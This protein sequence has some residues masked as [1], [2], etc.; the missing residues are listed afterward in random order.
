[1]HTSESGDPA[2]HV[3][4]HDREHAARDLARDLARAVD[5]GDTRLAW[6]VEGSWTT[7]ADEAKLDVTGPAGLMARVTVVVTRS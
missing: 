7:G 1:M 4:R 2:A 6:L 3:T 5:R